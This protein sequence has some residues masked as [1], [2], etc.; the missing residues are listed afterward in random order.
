MTCKNCGYEN[1]LG[2][3]YCQRCGQYIEPKRTLAQEV[4]SW[5]FRSLA[6]VGRRDVN[7]APLF[8]APSNQTPAKAHQTP[9][10]VEPMPDGRWYCPDCGILNDSCNGVQ[11]EHNKKLNHGL[12]ILHKVPPK[13]DYGRY[14]CIMAEKGGTSHGGLTEKLSPFFHAKKQEVNAYGR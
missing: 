11:R 14:F 5:D 12:P 4:K 2:V 9:S 7:I 13:R 10:P 3:R 1:R 8:T 6:G